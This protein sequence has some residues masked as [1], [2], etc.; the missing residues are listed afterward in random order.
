MSLRVYILEDEIITQE[1]LKETLEILGCFVCG[2]E[3]HAEKA[4]EEIQ[5]LDLDLVILDINVD[6]DKT[7]IWLGNQLEIPIIYLT[8]FSDLENIRNAVKTNPISYLQKPFKESDLLVAVELVKNKL[9]AKKQLTIKENNLT[10]NI[11]I[12][13]ILFAKKE[14]HYIII[15]LQD[16]K[17]VIRSTISEFL[18]KVTDDFV[19]V[20]RSYVINK[21][22]VTAHS[23]KMI[24]I[25]DVEIPI[26]N[27]FSKAVQE[28]L[29]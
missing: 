1:V 13:D 26:S 4:L 8:A 12:D 19:Q 14:D 11:N 10:I 5:Q 3:T 7:G 23:K 22:H 24:K 18:E 6:G 29:G 17:K 28:V 20:H 16:A 21:N 9:K 25:N 15:H 27:S 2:M